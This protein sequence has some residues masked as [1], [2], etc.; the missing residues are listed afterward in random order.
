MKANVTEGGRFLIKAA[1]WGSDPRGHLTISRML[2]LSKMESDGAKDC[3]L[4]HG[5]S[6]APWTFPRR[7]RGCAWFQFVF[8]SLSMFSSLSAAVKVK[9][10]EE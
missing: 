9:S 2:M 8:K 4:Q 5:H 3:S 1:L 6:T 7:V 10:L